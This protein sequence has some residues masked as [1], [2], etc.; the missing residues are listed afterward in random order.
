MTR[1]ELRGKCRVV[2]F[3]GGDFAS[4]LVAGGFLESRHL[5]CV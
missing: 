3:K 5:S 2:T 1:D 4:G